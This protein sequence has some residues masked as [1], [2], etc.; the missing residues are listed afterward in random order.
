MNPVLLKIRRA[1]CDVLLIGGLGT[2]GVGIYRLWSL[3]TGMIVV[4]LTCVVTA[5][6]LARE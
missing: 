5:V 4:G 6:L 1:A 2:A 3:N